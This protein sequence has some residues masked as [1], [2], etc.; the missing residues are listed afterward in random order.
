ML[1]TP[2][3]AQVLPEISLRVTP[4]FGI[5]NE[6]TV[7]RC[8]SGSGFSVGIRA[9]SDAEGVTVNILAH[10]VSD[11][12]RFRDYGVPAYIETTPAVYRSRTQ[13]TSP[14]TLW[15]ELNSSTFSG[16]GSPCF[17]D[18]LLITGSSVVRVILMPGTGYTVNPD[19]RSV[20]I[21]VRDT[22]GESCASPDNA[23]GGKYYMPH[24]QG[25]LKWGVCTCA[26]E[27][28]WHPQYRLVD[29]N[30]VWVNKG[31][32]GY[33]EAYGE[34]QRAW[35]ADTTNYCPDSPYQGPS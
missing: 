23:P 6:S 15:A 10:T 14:T 4:G 1:A 29:G 5:I 20:D 32:D 28:P 2:A 18:D 35:R 7:G 16:M 17:A 25:G 8:N 3:G 21:T 26:E 27:G 22:P 31:D 33:D 30:R 19:M 13:V 24:P 9:S 12:D 34:K 11:H